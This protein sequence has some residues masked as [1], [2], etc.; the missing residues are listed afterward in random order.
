MSNFSPFVSIS[1]FF[2]LSLTARFAA[3]N[4]LVP[5]A[6]TNGTSYLQFPNIQKAID[7]ALQ[8][9]ED[10]KGTP[11]MLVGE[12]PRKL[13]RAESLNIQ[14]ESEFS[15]RAYSHLPEATALR[16]HLGISMIRRTVDRPRL[17]VC[18]FSRQRLEDARW[19]GLLPFRAVILPSREHR[20]GQPVCLQLAVIRCQ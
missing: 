1:L 2:A 3:M 13:G 19:K 7:E 16:V 18:D 10:R 6:M 11:K 17:V 5:S 14:T 4:N 12:L 8:V 15:P 9:H 20:Q